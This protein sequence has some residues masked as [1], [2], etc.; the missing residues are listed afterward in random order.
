MTT[1]Y[2]QLET[3]STLSSIL[4]VR[5][6]R[7]L[8]LANILSIFSFVDVFRLLVLI[9]LR[10]SICVFSLRLNLNIF[11]L[12]DSGFRLNFPQFGIT[13]AA[14]HNFV[15]DQPVILEFN[16]KPMVVLVGRTPLGPYLPRV[17]LLC[18]RYPDDVLGIIFNQHA[19]LLHLHSKLWSSGQVLFLDD[20][21]GVESVGERIVVFMVRS[22]HNK[23]V[24]VLPRPLVDLSNFHKLGAHY[25]RA[26]LELHINH[27]SA[28][29]NVDHLHSSRQL[30]ATPLNFVSIR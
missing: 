23:S 1:T 10:I 24:V 30:Q 27:M 2:H 18:F 16:V 19:L 14:L 17:L 6:F 4:V 29:H 21:G 22:D 8:V 12:L 9:L 15:A 3:I 7:T 25:Q 28:S 26:V 20:S 11:L 5:H 13:L